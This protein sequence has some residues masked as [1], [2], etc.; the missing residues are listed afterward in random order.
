MAASSSGR[1]DRSTRVTKGG[2]ESSRKHHFESFTQRIAKL[3]IDPIRRVRRQD[4]DLDDL[5]A[6]TSYF[7]TGLSHWKDLNLS[8]NFTAF[9]REVEPLCDSLVQILHY[10]QKI[11]DI[12]CK[13][14]E[15]RDALSLEPL[16]SLTSHLAHDLGTRFETHF[17][18]VV[19]LVASLAAKHQSVE[20]IEWSFT[21][22]VWLFKY[23]SRLLVPDLRAVYNIMAPLLGK[24]PQKK[25][26]TKFA[27]EAMSFLVRKAALAYSKNKIPL[28]TF[29]GHIMEDLGRL[30]Q[31]GKD[32]GLYQYGLMTLF[33]DSIKGINRGLHSCGTTIWMCLLQAVTDQG[34]LFNRASL[35]VLHGVTVSIL[36]H[37]D[38]INFIP[39][40]NV[41]LD[42]IGTL[43][44]SSYPSAVSACAELLYVAV[45]VRKGSR[46]QDW[47]PV[48]NSLA[49]LLQ[50]D[51]ASDKSSNREILDYSEMGAAVIL[52]YSPLDLVIP[53]VRL[54]INCMLSE[55]RR[56]KFLLFCNYLCELGRD[57][58][59][60]LISP[61]F[62]KCVSLESALPAVLTGVTDI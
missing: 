62:F 36:H 48:V 10:H 40:L 7:Q 35:G 24:E 1:R 21:C 60:S 61:S 23:L 8:E 46:I 37:T 31:Q 2:T 19:T 29:V 52:Q 33:A 38:E 17:A 49:L 41:L 53:K 25:Y 9:V 13:Y 6:T 56:P 11:V 39:I 50:F 43:S 4:V 57:R 5:S 18:K 16:L 28:T 26:V 59:L 22:L 47:Q 15:I 44:E 32:T 58:F 51:H 34:R 12:L 27:A 3:N 55:T 45:T 14:M 30:I 20:V 54:V 42:S